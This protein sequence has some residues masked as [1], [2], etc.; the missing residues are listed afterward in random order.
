MLTIAPKMVIEVFKE[1]DLAEKI[2]VSMVV[3]MPR[4]EAKNIPSLKF[5]SDAQPIAM[6][7]TVINS[8]IQ[9][10]LKKYS[11]IFRFLEG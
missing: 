8:P 3:N 7:T 9:Y 6:K 11:I 10:F 4:H 2:I 5:P 1:P